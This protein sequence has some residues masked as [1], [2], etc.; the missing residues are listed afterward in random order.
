[1]GRSGGKT[2]DRMVELLQRAVEESSQSAVARDTGLRLYSIQRYLKGVGE[3]SQET[4]EKLVVYF[5]VSFGYLRGGPR[6][7]LDRL[8]EGVRAKGLS[9]ES[10]NKNLDEKYECDKDFGKLLMQQE[11]YPLAVIEDQCMLYDI[12]PYWVATGRVPTVLG[13][14]R[15]YVGTIDAPPVPPPWMGVISASKPTVQA[16][17][18]APSFAE[19]LRETNEILEESKKIAELY[20]S[21]DLHTVYN[22][23]KGQSIINAIEAVIL[24]NQERVRQ[25]LEII[26]NE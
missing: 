12:D 1:M 16:G 2:P 10:Y 15:G 18:K 7:P 8:L 26:N 21:L 9:I 13:V 25:L 23:K 6:E 11:E 20:K 19:I 3:P 17:E 5:G 4:L 22:K 14:S 24:E